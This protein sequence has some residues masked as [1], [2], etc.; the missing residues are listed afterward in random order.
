MILK[1]GKGEKSLGKENFYLTS[2]ELRDYDYLIITDS[3]GGMTIDLNFHNSFILLL[4]FFLESFNKSYIIISRPKNLTVFATLIN[5]LKL[6]SDLRFKYLVTNLGF[7]D[8]TPK[9]QKNIDDIMSQIK[10]FSNISNTIIKHENYELNDG[11]S[12]ILKSVKYKEKYLIEITQNLNQRFEKCYFIN[13][14]IVNHSMKMERERPNSFFQ[15]LHVT[16][17]LINDL[18]NLNGKNMLID[19]KE[20]NCTYDGVHYTKKGHEMIFHKI[21]ESIK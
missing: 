19:I 15:Q 8:C 7:V 10:Q 13:T 16:N 9:K 2:H 20:F 14:P 6:N 17:K 21:K 4:S 3:R 12:E 1:F 5:F 18:V 11:N